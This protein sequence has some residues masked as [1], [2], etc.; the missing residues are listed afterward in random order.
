MLFQISGLRSP[1]GFAAVTDRG[2]ADADQVVGH[3]LRKYFAIDIVV[4]ECGRVLSSAKPRATP[5]RPSSKSSSACEKRQPLM[6]D[7]RPLPFKLPAAALK[8]AHYRGVAAS[9]GR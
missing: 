8:Q 5:L 1:Q 2:H 7:D 9:A 3:Q 6:N 4:V